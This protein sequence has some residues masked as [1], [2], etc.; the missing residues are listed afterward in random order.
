MRQMTANPQEP[1]FVQ[2]SKAR[3]TT[4]QGQ[5]T[6]DVGKLRQLL[7]ADEIWIFAVRNGDSFRLCG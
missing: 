2:Q 3:E 6:L 1:V 5:S 4:D 7:D